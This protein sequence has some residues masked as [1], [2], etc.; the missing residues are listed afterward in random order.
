[1]TLIEKI[2]RFP[3]QLPS[4]EHHIHIPDGL[5]VCDYVGS[6]GFYYLGSSPR[7]AMCFRIIEDV[8]IERHIFAFYKVIEL[9]NKGRTQE[10]NKRIRDPEFRIGW[11]ARL[12][13]DLGQLFSEFS[14]SN[15]PTRVPTID[16][17]VSVRTATV[18]EDSHG[19][20]RPESFWSS[21]VDRIEGWANED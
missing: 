8:G 14:P 19:S 18:R 2:S 20:N 9:S 5:Y 12:A 17:S 11:R 10:K 4:A 3:S 1:M 21:K 7:L 13:R 15:L 6:V 16:N